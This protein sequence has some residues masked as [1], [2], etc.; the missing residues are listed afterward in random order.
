MAVRNPS[1]T[2]NAYVSID[3]LRIDASKLK[4]AKRLLG[5]ESDVETLNKALAMVIANEEMEL[6]IERAYGTDPAV[7]SASALEAR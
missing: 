5:L 4:R 2:R 6:A 7:S 3:P 1:A